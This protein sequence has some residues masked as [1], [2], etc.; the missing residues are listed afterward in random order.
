VRFSARDTHPW[1]KHETSVVAHEFH[2]ASIDGLP[3]DSQ[4]ACDMMRGVGVDGKRDGL[5]IANTLAGFCHL[6]NTDLNP[7]VTRFLTF[8]ES[9]KNR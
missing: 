8:V 4:F 6:R 2:Y 7:W 1:G 5:V 9:C 3:Q